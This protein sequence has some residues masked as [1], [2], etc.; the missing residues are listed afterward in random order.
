[1]K[2]LQDN[3]VFS[4]AYMKQKAIQDSR[5]IRNTKEGQDLSKY[6]NAKY[7]GMTHKFVEGKFV[8]V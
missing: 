1:M 8:K 4:D 2:D 3:K 7:A 6:P 5:I